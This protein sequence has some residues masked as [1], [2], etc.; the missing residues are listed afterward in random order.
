MLSEDWAVTLAVVRSDGTACF[1]SLGPRSQCLLVSSH[2]YLLSS[3]TAD[4]E[5]VQATHYATLQVLPL[6]T[7]PWLFYAQCLT[8]N[9]TLIIWT[10]QFLNKS[11]LFIVINV[12]HWELKT[13]TC[14]YIICNNV[15]FIYIDIDHYILCNLFFDRPLYFWPMHHWPFQ[16]AQLYCDCH[17][18][19]CIFS[20]LW[21]LCDEECWSV[22]GT[23]WHNAL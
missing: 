9:Y 8:V 11:I 10:F 22:G 13:C 19:L 15:W 16:R 6:I 12:E 20:V 23:A 18:Q 14:A 3:F 2:E 17:C 7:L 5:R 4:I 21:E 1:L